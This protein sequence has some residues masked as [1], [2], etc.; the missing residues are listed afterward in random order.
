MSLVPCTT[1]DCNRTTSTYLCAQCV[2]DLQAWID[3]VPELREQLFITMARLD[4]TRPT[5]QTGGNGGKADSLAPAR[6]G[7]ME[8]RYALL[9]WEGSKASDLAKEEHAGGYLKMLKKLIDHGEEIVLGEPETRVI[10]TCDCGGKVITRKPAPQPTDQEPYPDDSGTCIECAKAVTTNPRDTRLRILDRCP[11]GL[12]T[13]DALKWISD[14]AGIR[15]E[16]TDVRNWARENKITRTNPDEKG[17]PKYHVADILRVHFRKLD[18][19]KR[20]EQHAR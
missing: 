4:N 12:P 8:A 13:R 20:K 14:N 3:K 2:S 15:V 11:E 7:A 9:F 5:G 16:P 19:G 18:T 6:F 17:H 1:P 10:T